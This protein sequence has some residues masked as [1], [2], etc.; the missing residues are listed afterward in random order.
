VLEEM[1]SAQLLVS[2]PSLRTWAGSDP[3]PMLTRILKFN[4]GQREEKTPLLPARRRGRG[5]RGDGGVLSCGRQVPRPAEDPRREAGTRMVEG[6]GLKGEQKW[7]RNRNPSVGS[8]AGAGRDRCERFLR[9]GSRERRR[10]GISLCFSWDQG[11][12]Q[13]GGAPP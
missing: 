10:A 4:H 6:Q 9:P 8:A 2:D 11:C 13:N 3:L 1:V 12:D 5:M 7:P